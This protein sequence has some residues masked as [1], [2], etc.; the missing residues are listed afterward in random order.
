V[1]RSQTALTGAACH[2]RRGNSAG[3]AGSIVTEQSALFGRIRSFAAPRDIESAEEAGRRIAVIDVGSNSVR[4]VVFDGIARSPAY[5]FNE[6]VLCG[7]GRG[8]SETGRLNPDGVARARVTLRRFAELAV[9]MHVSA[10]EAV[11]TA[12]VRVAE[13]GRQFVAQIE[14]ETGIRIRIATG[15]EEARLSAQGVLLGR[16]GAEGLVADIGGVSMELGRIAGGRVLSGVTTPLGPFPLRDTGLKGRTLADWIDDRLEAAAERV[17]GP[18]PE[19]FLV[20]GAWRALARVHMARHGYPL[21]V[22]HE[23]RMAPDDLAAEALRITAET[24]DELVALSRISRSRAENLPLNALVLHR[25]L[26][27]LRPA[28]VS[29]SIFGLREGVLWDHLGPEDRARDP[30]IEACRFTETSRARFP[31]FGQTLFDWLRPVLDDFAP[32]ERRLALA[33][34][35]LHDV[36]WRIHPDFRPMMG[37]ETMIRALSGGIDHKGRVFVGLALYYRY[38][39]SRSGRPVPEVLGLL[40]RTAQAHAE[41]LGRAMRLGAMLSASTDGL[42]EALLDIVDGKLR[43]VLQGGMRDLAG[44]VV[45]K[46]LA[47][48]ARVIQLAPELVCDGEVER[49][50]MSG[51]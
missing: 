4:L 11:A 20:G 42:E 14:Q 7:L 45:E 13:D 1:A 6:K 33:A 19:L 29:L 35:L 31:G 39:S 49:R 15:A 43:L 28:R 24:P 12:A 27:V 16:P 34:C 50:S 47:G 10:L 41:R 30:L 37:F 40:D 51:A 21:S 44:E 17:P 38:S 26:A 5:F 9:R 48:L 3:Q 2:A 22:L 8:V 25:A 18:V 46:R 36:N 23:Y 32:R